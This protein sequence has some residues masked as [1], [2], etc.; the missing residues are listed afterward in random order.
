MSGLVTT[1]QRFGKLGLAFATRE[2][3]SSS[4]LLRDP[5]GTLREEGTEVA[6]FALTAAEPVV[7]AK[8]S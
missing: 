8:I 7:V 4:F 2:G 5:G 6:T 1:L 3:S